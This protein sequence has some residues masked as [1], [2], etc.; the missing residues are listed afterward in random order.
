VTATTSRAGAPSPALAPPPG[1]P[2]FAL[3]D[4]LRGIAVLAVVVF[5]V[6]LV[7]GALG[8]PVTGDA[9]TVLGSLGPILFFAISGFLLYRPWVAAREG[10]AP[11]PSSARYARRRALRILPAYWFALTVLGVLVGLAGVLGHD[12]WRYYFFLQVYDADTAGRGI[13]VAWTLCVEVAFYAL[14][15]LWALATRRA[16]PATDLTALAVL[17]LCGAAIQVAGAR[18]EVSHQL[19]QSLAGQCTWMAIGMALAVLSVAGAPGRGLRAAIAHPGLCWTG[20]ALAFAGLTALRHDTGGVLGLI[21]GVGTVQPWGRA[22]G[23]LVLLA[24]L[25][26]L[27][28]VPAVFDERA[29]GLPRRILAVPGLVWLGVVSYGVYLWHLTIAE[30]LALDEAPGHF[31]ASGLALAET[32]TA[33]RMPILLVLTLAASCAVAWLSYRFVELPFLRR[34]DRRR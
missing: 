1:N 9:A 6:F 16:R 10:R 30:L 13:P 8:R 31:T 5:H 17:A 21:R 28:M 18:L 25:I 33:A 12:W 19:A 22:L 11:T 14:L 24:A 32:L 7:S 15:P 34:K 2:R 20:A 23:E 29:G 27:L 4:S 3:F 26:V